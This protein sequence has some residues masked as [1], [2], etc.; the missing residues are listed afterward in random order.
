MKTI[1][2][3]EFR[4]QA[5]TLL[6]KVES[7]E[8]FIIIRHGKPIAE[9]SPFVEDSAIEPAWKQPGLRLQLKGADLTTAILAEREASS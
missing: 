9:V 6:T 7:G 4:K 3:T 1:T 2:F 8:T 5:S